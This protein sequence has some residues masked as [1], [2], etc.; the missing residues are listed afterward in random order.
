M[1]FS[2]NDEEAKQEMLKKKKLTLTT[3]LEILEAHEAVKKTSNIL[4]DDTKVQKVQ[5]YLQHQAKRKQDDR[6]TN[7]I[8]RQCGYKEHRNGVCPAKGEKC[9]KCGK[10]NHFARVCRSLDNDRDTSNG[11]SQ[12]TKYGMGS[13]V[14]S[15]G[16]LIDTVTVEC[17]GQMI[18]ADVDTGSSWCC[19]NVEGL[20]VI[21]QSQFNL[22]EPT[23]AMLNT[24]N[25]TGDRMKVVGYLNATFKF[26]DSSTTKP[27]VV[28]KGVRGFILSKEA[29]IE[30]K[31]VTINTTPK[32]AQVKT[33][34]QHESSISVDS[35]V[36]KE[37]P[38]P[39]C[40]KSPEEV[41]RE[42]LLIE[43][44]DVFA[45]REE[46]LKGQPFRIELTTDAVPHKV[47][48]PRNI[49]RP[50][51]SKL[52][53]EL[54]K[55]MEAGFIEEVTWAT[56]WVSPIVVAPKRG[57]NDIRLCVDFRRLNEFCKRE[58]YQSP[59]AIECVQYINAEEAGY[60][61]KFDATKGFHQVE[62]HEDC[63]DLTTFLTPFGR[64]RFKRAPFG[65]TSIPEHYNRRMTEALRG[66]KGITRFVDD[67][68]VYGRD[69]KEHLH[70]VRKFLERC[71]EERIRL[72]KE[73]FVYNKE[74]IEFAGL[75]V[76][77][78]G[79]QIH[80]KTVAALKEFPVPTSISDMR[81]FHG[82]A[83][84]L[85][86]FDNELAKKLEPLRHLLKPRNNKKFEMSKDEVRT[87]NEVKC[88]LSSPATL[89]Y[90]QPGQP[91]QLYTD[92]ACTKGYG[93]VLQQRQSSGQ[94]R[95]IM[96]GSRSLV[97]AETR[98]APIESELT[99]M[100]WSLRK[101]RRFL[102]GVP[103]FKVFT[104]HRPLVSLVNKRRFDEVTNT[105]L[106]RNLLKC[107]DFN[108]EVV[109]IKG[110]TNVAAD[111]LSRNPTNTPD[112]QDK[113]EAEETKFHVNS[114]RIS[115]LKEAKCTLNMEKVKDAGSQDVEYRT[116]KET[117]LNGFPD[118]KHQLEDLVKPYWP[119]KEN[120]TVSD[121]D[122]VL[123]GTRLVIPQALRGQVLTELHAGH[124]GIEG[125]KARARLVVYWPGIDNMIEQK[126]RSCSECE[127]DR[128]SQAAEPQIHLPVPT[129]Y[130]EN[131]SADFAEVD[132][133]PFLVTTDWR[134]GWFTTVK[135]SSTNSKSTIQILRD[136]F[137]DTRVPSI[138][139]T[140]NGPPFNS[141]EF[142][143]FCRN[144]GVRHI[145]SSP[146]YAQSNSYA[147]NGVK[148]AKALLRKCFSNG[149][150][151]REKWA[152]GLLQIRNTPH[153]ATGLSPAVMLYGHAVNDVVPAH[154]SA[155]SKSWHKELA[156]Y[157][158]KIACER[159]RMDKY[160]GGRSLPSL[161]E[162][163][164]VVI[165]NR[166][167]KRWDRY[168]VVQESKPDIRKYVVR[169][170]SGMITV[171]NRRDLRK[172]YPE[173][174]CNGGTRQWC[175]IVVS[176][177]E[178]E[179]VPAGDEEHQYLTDDGASSRK[180]KF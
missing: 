88:Y 151:D 129:H 12:S 20:K 166:Q 82:L 34:H 55:L 153:K 75:L 156:A 67:T 64:F 177:S 68:M 121:D 157:D 77:K 48:F 171:R 127:K 165:Q 147:E 135:V 13:I 95:T 50:Y 78:E 116:L 143:D 24:F 14:C 138:L 180:H 170:P 1:V 179:A 101:A 160:R 148:Q 44:A 104:D 175:P 9:L 178:H 115:T 176:E 76:N 72:N 97:E 111:A 65:I 119:I 90:Y 63:R 133:Q 71:R 7:E 174:K 28:F 11:K 79:F 70:N 167:N 168:G 10:Q 136:F 47:H 152:K 26:G 91:V 30:L 2:T 163:T 54:K 130:F 107:A 169:M 33:D 86:P 46:P 122:F 3:A 132:G 83:N 15:I 62:L 19:C 5:S 140:D 93:F 56:E 142:S 155:L 80:P 23:K 109:Y 149:R 52:E 57:T 173:N 94:W 60:F 108:M 131:I 120:L 61:S 4:S 117:I 42:D 18:T 32:V 113:D 51:M 125:I 137:A 161:P 81:S 49:A 43:F 17:Q 164:A 37:N 124:R 29:L 84:Q 27:L 118:S 106:L 172:R 69:K 150:L 22:L 45:H 58:Y 128:P 53:E 89:A 66:L 39:Q 31:I 139:F 99:A 6:K 123:Y 102:L 100:A 87:F 162:G 21:K 35:T 38:G 74:E 112:Q 105:R 40:T 36:L 92:A 110:S 126:C 41:T 98:Y 146:Y 8:C 141:A 158:R 96:V 154:K 159:Q 114:V 59:G 73:K 144:W 85:N 25:A 16:P 134:S 145:T 103:K